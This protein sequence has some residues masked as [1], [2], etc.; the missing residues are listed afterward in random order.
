MLSHEDREI[1]KSASISANNLFMD[2]VELTKADDVLLAEISSD[3]MNSANAILQKLERLLVI[4]DE[5]CPK[6]RED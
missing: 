1:L 2:M 6:D 4:T 5:P 3:L